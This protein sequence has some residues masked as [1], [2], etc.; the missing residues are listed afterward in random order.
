MNI[1]VVVIDPTVTK[2]E[3]I[4][5]HNGRKSHRAPILGQTFNTEGCSDDRWKDAKEEA[6]GHCYPVTSTP[7]RE[8]GDA[9]GQ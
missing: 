8:I 1:R 7:S 6:V 5:K 2:V 4:A 9:Y 3:N